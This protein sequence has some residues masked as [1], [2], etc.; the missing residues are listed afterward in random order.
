MKSFIKEIFTM[1]RDDIYCILRKNNL[2]WNFINVFMI[3]SI[4]FG[5]IFFFIGLFICSLWLVSI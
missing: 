3:N 2:K 4:V 1:Y 5:S